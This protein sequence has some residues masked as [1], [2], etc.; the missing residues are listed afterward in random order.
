MKTSHSSK[1]RYGYVETLL[2]MPLVDDDLSK[3]SDLLF[4]FIPPCEAF[5]PP[6]LLLPSPLKTKPMI[7][8]S[9]L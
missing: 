5:P 7:F 8:R 3:F 9:V 1:H 4:M 2:R 6:S